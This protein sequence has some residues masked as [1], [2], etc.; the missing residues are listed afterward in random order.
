MPTEWQHKDV[1]AH[2]ENTPLVQ[3]NQNWREIIRSSRLQRKCP[4]TVVHHQHHQEAP[5][6]W[7][8]MAIETW[9]NW[10]WFKKG[11]KIYPK[12]KVLIGNLEGKMVLQRRRREQKKQQSRERMTDSRMDKANEISS[13]FHQ[14]ILG[15][16]KHV[17]KLGMDVP[18]LTVL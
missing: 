6:P 7:K 14:S 9:I 2:K 10:Q 13:E 12:I 3:A 17:V 18:H 16:G 5:M 11:F 15:H 1:P 4:H 8:E